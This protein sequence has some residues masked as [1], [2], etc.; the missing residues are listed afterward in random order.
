MLEIKYLVPKPVS[1]QLKF[2]EKKDYFTYDYTSREEY[3]NLM[4]YQT[5][6]ID[7]LLVGLLVNHRNDEDARKS[8]ALAKNEAMKMQPRPVWDAVHHILQALTE[9]AIKRERI[10]E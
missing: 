3:L 1:D 9:K 2:Q 8:T 10:P 6:R 5:M 7:A 4:D